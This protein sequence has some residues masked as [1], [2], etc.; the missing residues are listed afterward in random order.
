MKKPKRIAALGRV[1]SREQ[2]QEGYSLEV[3]EKAIREYAEEQGAVLVKLF[4]APESAKV[5]AKRVVFEEF[6]TF[7]KDPKNRIDKLVFHKVDRACRTLQDLAKLEELQST[8]GITCKYLDVGLDT[9]SPL[10]EHVVTHVA[11]IARLQ[12][13]QSSERIL[14]STE[15]R[16]LVHGLFPGRAPYAYRNV[17]TSKKSSL[18]EVHDEHGPKI[19]QIFLML[20]DNPI[21]V[22]QLQQRLFEE[23]IF[24]TAKSPRFPLTKL[25]T[26]L[27]D[28]AYIREIKFRGEWHACGSFPALVSRE[29]FDRVQARLGK[30]QN[31]NGHDLLFAGGLIRCGD[32]GHA[33]TGEV[34]KKKYTYYHCTHID[35][36]EDHPR[37]RLREEA[38]DEQVLLM[39][40]SLQVEAEEVR[41]WFVDVIRARAEES[42]RRSRTRRSKLQEE[43]T[44]VQTMKDE[45]LDLRL[46]QEVS[47]AA[48]RRKESQLLEREHEL[49]QLLHHEAKAQTEGGDAAI[50]VLEL[51][52]ALTQKWVAADDATK[53]NLLDLLCLNLTL[54][55]KTLVPE[56][57]RPFNL[58]AE[59]LLVGAGEN[60][61]GG[62]S[63]TRVLE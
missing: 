52:Q 34:Q 27:H 17:R 7:V 41:E 50:R 48:Y 43:L 59:G 25:Y 14:E 38:L 49:E 16:V 55:G 12:I 30:K 10:G 24:Y 18:V 33:I 57:R 47:Q 35:R 9:A 56:L 28:R 44:K 58:L 26:I 45:L 51:S 19:P 42:Q 5:S 36:K 40:D 21:T 54:E 13:R 23:G 61:G 22:P 62:G 46:Q 37:V 2:H 3:Q 32:C 15:E 1:S 53:R 11:S 6:L 60:G 39:L 20:A 4:S 63:R 8:H 29:L 31:P